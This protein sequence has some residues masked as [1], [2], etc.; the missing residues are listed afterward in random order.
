ML[1]RF[2]IFGRNGVVYFDKQFVKLRGDPLSEL[3]LDVL[4]ENR[5]ASSST[6]SGQYTLKWTFDT[7]MDLVFVVILFSV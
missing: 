7:A 2:I 1:D 3:I 6:T 5:N 4:L